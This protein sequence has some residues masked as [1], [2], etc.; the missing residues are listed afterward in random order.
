MSGCGLDIRSCGSVA[1]TDTRAAGKGTYVLVISYCTEISDGL[2]L[3][4]KYIQ[5]KKRALI[6]STVL[7]QHTSKKNIAESTAK[8]FGVKSVVWKYNMHNG[9]NIWNSC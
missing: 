9:G 4:L 5:S 8:T 7:Q 3:L 1:T 6:C 2:N